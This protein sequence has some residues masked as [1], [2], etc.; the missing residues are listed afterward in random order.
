MYVPDLQKKLIKGFGFE[1]ERCLLIKAKQGNIEARNSL[2]VS[3]LPFVMHA[4]RIAKEKAWAK[5]KYQTPQFLTDDL[6]QEGVF[7]DIIGIK[8]FDLSRKSAQGRGLRYCTYGYWWIIESISAAIKVELKW[9]VRHLYLFSDDVDFFA[10]NDY[11]QF[12]QCS[13]QKV[14]QPVYAEDQKNVVLCNK[15]DILE[16]LKDGRAL[17]SLD[18]LKFM[19][20]LSNGQLTQKQRDI[21]DLYYHDRL[22]NSEI[23]KKLGHTGGWVSVLRNRALDVLREQVIA[24]SGD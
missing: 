10:E 15:S 22:T 4:V 13:C 2:I 14:D 7:G 1:E 17:Q 12:Q 24:Y 19:L 21:L 11:T 18:L 8:R 5:L 16:E 3:H 20:T 9:D 23:G 6:I